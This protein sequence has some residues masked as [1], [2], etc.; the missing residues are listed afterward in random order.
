MIYSIKLERKASK[1]LKKIPPQYQI[2]IAKRIDELANNPKK[3]G[4]ELVGNLNG[5]YSSRV[6]NYR[7]LYKTQD[8]ELI[9]LVIDIGHRKNI[10]N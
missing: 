9:V 8:D 6:G 4:K 7:I 3:A 10:Y 1:K 5:L 2:R